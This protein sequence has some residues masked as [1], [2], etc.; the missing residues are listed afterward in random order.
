MKSGPQRG[1]EWSDLSPNSRTLNPNS[2]ETFEIT[3]NKELDLEIS[4]RFNYRWSSS[5]SIWTP[6]KQFTLHGLRRM[7]QGFNLALKSLGFDRIDESW[8]F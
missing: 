8:V 2:D 1:V 3:F 5:S 4:K 6:W 7:G